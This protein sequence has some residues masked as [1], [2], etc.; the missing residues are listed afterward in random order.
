MSAREE[1]VDWDGNETVVGYSAENDPAKKLQPSANML[2]LLLASWRQVKGAI[3]GKEDASKDAALKPE[4]RKPSPEADAR[5]APPSD[6]AKAKSRTDEK[7][8]IEVAAAGPASS[9]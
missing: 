7:S 3:A 2:L 6:E 8:A 9:P 4:A 1:N 5:G